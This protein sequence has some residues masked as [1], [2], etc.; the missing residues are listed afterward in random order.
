[1]NSRPGAQLG[2]VWWFI[3]VV[4]SLVRRVRDSV[5]TS[6]FGEPAPAVFASTRRLVRKEPTPV[7]PS[8]MRTT[9]AALRAMPVSVS[10]LDEE[11]APA[12]HERTV[13]AASDRRDWHSVAVGS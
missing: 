8:E 1:M 7:E 4:P 6:T 11:L 10:P 12:F 13:D 9:A 3:A 5:A 2:S